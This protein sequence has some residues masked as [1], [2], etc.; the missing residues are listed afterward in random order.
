MR[1]G[2]LTRAEGCRRAGA[3][4]QAL[5]QRSRWYLRIVPML[6]MNAEVPCTYA[7]PTFRRS[8]PAT[9]LGWR[10][11]ELCCFARCP[12]FRCRL[13]FLTLAWGTWTVPCAATETPAPETTFARLAGARASLRPTAPIAPM[14]ISVQQ[15]TAAFLG[16]V[17]VKPFPKASRATTATCAQRENCARA[18]CV[19]RKET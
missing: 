13:L 1:C 9:R 8:R 12:G 18:A 2:K 17:W 7:I 5:A 19:R 4:A 10:Q 6:P 11:R 14:A 15:P 3:Q 16:F